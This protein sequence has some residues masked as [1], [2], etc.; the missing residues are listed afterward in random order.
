MCAV[1]M[2]ESVCC[3]GESSNF[4]FYAESTIMVI[5]RQSGDRECMLRVVTWR[6]TPSQPLRLYMGNQVREGM[7]CS[8]E[9]ACAVRE[10]VDDNCGR[11]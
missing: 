1:Q 9:T 3:S 8:G 5:S 11:W 4:I 2:R 6:F 7:C 10:G